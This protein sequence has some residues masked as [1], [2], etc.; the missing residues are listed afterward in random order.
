M[1]HNNLR[2]GVASS[3]F[4]ELQTEAP[5]TGGGVGRSLPIQTGHTESHS[6]S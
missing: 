2:A 3:H 1:I 4:T 6:V 5:V